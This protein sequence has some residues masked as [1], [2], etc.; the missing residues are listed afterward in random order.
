MDV[1]PVVVL[2]AV[3]IALSR[4]AFRLPVQRLS[5]LAALQAGCVPASVHGKQIEPVRD[6]MATPRAY[7]HVFDRGRWCWRCPRV[8]VLL[9]LGVK[10]RRG[11][12]IAV[13][14][15]AAGAPAM[16][17]GAVEREPAQTGVAVVVARRERSVVGA[18]AGGAGGAAVA[19]A[20]VAGLH[21]AHGRRVARVD[22]QVGRQVAGRVVCRAKVA[23]VPLLL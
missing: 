19:G 20:A 5:T 9:D 18:A 17:P 2:P 1:L 10:Q 4:V 8:R 13:A 21:V 6:A 3:D 16:L 15:G 14:E 11:E 12:G 23:I 7:H 22:R